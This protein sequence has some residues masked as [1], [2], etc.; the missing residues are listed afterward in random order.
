ML[1]QIVEKSNISNWAVIA[2]L[3]GVLAVG[4]FKLNEVVDDVNKQ[5][6]IIQEL[7]NKQ[8]LND[9]KFATVDKEQT[10][11]DKT[12]ETVNNTLQEVN[13]TLSSLKATIESMKK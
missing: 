10:K 1:S 9:L 13:T 5:E 11:F 3:I 2:S 12:L 8:S 4:N 6:A 7:R